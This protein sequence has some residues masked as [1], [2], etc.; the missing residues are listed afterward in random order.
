[1]TKLIHGAGGALGGGGNQQKQEKARQPVITQDNPGLKTISF[2]KMQFLLCEGPIAGPANGAGVAAL[3]QSIYLDSTPIRTAAGVIP[4]PEDLVLSYG[5]PTA[6]QT[7]TP[8]YGNVSNIIAVDKVVKKDLPITQQVIA[9]DPTVGYSARVLLTWQGLFRQI[10]GGPTAGDVLPHSC[11]YGITYTDNMGTVRGPGQIALEDKFSGPFQKEAEFALEGPGPWTIRVDRYQE[12]DD[13]RQAATGENYQSTFSFSSIVL[14]T[15]IGLRY[16][17]SSILTLGVRA[18]QYSDIPA[19]A[20]DLLGLIIKVPN[21]YDTINRTYNGLWNGGFKYAYTNNPAWVIYDLF[22]ND[23]YGLGKYVDPQLIDKWALYEIAQYCDQYVPDGKGG[24]EPRFTCNIILQTA[25]EAWTVLQQFSSIFR[26]ILYYAAS[27]IVTVQDRPKACVYTFNESNTIEQVDEDS[28]QV[29]EGNFS[30]SGSAK[31]ARHTAVLVS[32]DDPADSYQ[33]RVEYIPDQAGMLKLGYRPLQLRLMG[34]TSRGQALRAANW[35]LLTESLLDDTVSFGTGAVG[36][37]L[38]PG[39]LIKIAD[40]GKAAIRMGGRVQAIDGDAVLVDQAPTNPPGGWAG[41]TFSFMAPDADGQPVLRV[42]PLPAPAGDR[43]SPAWTTDDRPQPG[44]PWLIEVPGRTAQEFRVLTVTESSTDQEITYG[45]T[46]L[47]YRGDIYDAVDFGA[48]LGPDGTALWKPA[49][50]KPPTWTIAQVVWDGGQAKLDLA[51]Q[52]PASDEYLGDFNLS[53]SSYRVQFLEGQRQGDGSILWSSNWIKAPRSFD[54]AERI[55]TPA[56]TG[57]TIYK[58]RVAAV[59]RIGV[60]SEWA[61]KQA[62]TMEEWFPMPDL[63]KFGILKHENL[64]TGGHEFS[65]SVAP[66][67]PVPPYV[68]GKQVEASEAGVWSIIAASNLTAI[69]TWTFASSDSSKPVRLSLTTFVPDV[70][71]RTYATDYVDRQEIV[72]PPPS[73]LR[74]VMEGGAQSRTGQRRFS[75]QL[76]ATPFP[77]NWPQ[78]VANDITAF[79]IR[80]RQD[81]TPDWDRA[82][83]LFSDGIPGDQTWFQTGLFDAGTWTVMIRSRD[84]TGWRSDDMAIVTVGIGDAI[85][86]NVVQRYDLRDDG[87]PGELDNFYRVAVAGNDLMYPDPQS[88]AIYYDP[89]DD[90]FYEGSSGFMLVQETYGQRYVPVYPDAGPMYASSKFYPAADAPPVAAPAVMSSYTFQFECVNDKAQLILYT[91]AV[92]TY[93]WFVQPGGRDTDLTYEQPT[94][95]PFYLPDGLMY[96]IPDS[97]ASNG[98]HPY[99]AHEELPQGIH[100][101][102]LDVITDHVGAPAMVTDVD[103]VLDYP[104]VV[105]TINDTLLPAGGRRVTFPAGTFRSLKAV[106]VTMQDD[107]TQPGV[108]SNAVIRLKDPGFVDL[109]PIDSAG[110]A[111]DGVADLICV[112]W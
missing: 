89:I 74:V 45:I 8:G 84:R 51:W 35:A 48:P 111:A 3:E 34:V 62:L 104:D 87:F 44:W 32:W 109:Q 92:G 103:V 81:G 61:E 68:R 46:A 27:T 13:D 83:P 6:Q 101:L 91:S 94:S 47:R 36:A 50:I 73:N 10:V 54:N 93:R 28:G 42:S 65:F 14:S 69:D 52:P 38:R 49:A 90:Q 1:M 86:S 37:A 24:V 23:R 55:I 21:N 53:V 99:A 112:G 7:A 108:A 82:F 72:P 25:E 106:A 60:Q 56:Y 30:Y 57:S 88:G 79:D 11:Y 78:G 98:W 100:L 66:G 107:G 26:G 29:S 12:D 41:A 75:W 19:V 102:R 39:D 59:S 95:D 17:H 31:R 9:T 64:S 33:P 96:P 80:Y 20:A 105:W 40:P 43:L 110:A 63:S 22:I 58:V 15:W 4:Q 67:T 5:R 76:D 85:P 16:P 97:A 70:I 18:D 71:G 2:A 77:Q